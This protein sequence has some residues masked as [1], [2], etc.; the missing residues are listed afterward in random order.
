MKMAIEIL[1]V[2]EEVLADDF[3]VRMG[4]ELVEKVEDISFLLLAPIVYPS[5][6][7]RHFSHHGADMGNANSGNFGPSN[8]G[9]SDVPA[10]GFNVNREFKWPGFHQR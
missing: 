1:S 10:T 3:G 7:V 5:L 4:E 9:A 8:S 6:P 2:V